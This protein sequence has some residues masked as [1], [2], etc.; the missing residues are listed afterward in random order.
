[1]KNTKHTKT[2]KTPR[3]RRCA[4]AANARAAGA[5]PTTS[6]DSGSPPSSPPLTAKQTRF[7]AEFLIDLNAAGAARRAGFTGK[8]SDQ[9]G[10]ELLRNPEIATAIA[11]GKARQLDTA[12]LS[13]ARVLE[14]LRRLAFANVRDFFDPVTKDA[15]HPIELT[16]EQGACLAGF[17][18]LIKNAKAGD[19][20]TDTVH[21]FKLWDK[22]HSLELLAKHFE[23][24]V[25]RVK[26]DTTNADARIARLMAT[27]KRTA[28][29]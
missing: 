4:A 13:A 7:V 12:E 18:V 27:L 2:T 9:A 24:L 28:A 11:F 10:Y 22:V 29:K 14:E 15:K 17:E 5:S 21:K 1:M 3:R 19:G 26:V 20:I 8:R 16:N 23:L 25:E 6:I